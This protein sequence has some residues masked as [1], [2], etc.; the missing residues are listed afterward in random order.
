M[1]GIFYPQAMFK[2]YL[3]P[4]LH[5]F[6]IYNPCFQQVKYLNNHDA[7]KVLHCYLK[8]EISSIYCCGLLSQDKNGSLHF[9]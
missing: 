2:C 9:S 6:K 7:Q 1:A 4:P 3:A 5:R 8:L